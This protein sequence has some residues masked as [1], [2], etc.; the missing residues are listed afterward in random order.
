HKLTLYLPE[1]NGGKAHG[2]LF[3]LREDPWELENRY[4]DEAFRE[5]RDRLSRELYEWLVRS[6]R[7]Q[8]VNP[9]TPNSAPEGAGPWTS[10]RQPPLYGR[11]GKVDPTVIRTLIGERK[12]NYL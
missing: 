12:I 3:D 11:D 6:S 8:T 10:G 5:T 2:E 4:E 9:R 1:M 7:H